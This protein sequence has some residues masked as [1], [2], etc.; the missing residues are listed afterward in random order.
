MKRLQSLERGHQFGRQI[1]I[2][3]RT[4]EFGQN[5]PLDMILSAERQRDEFF[6]NLTFTGTDQ[7]KNRLRFVAETSD[8]F[9]TSQ[10]ARPLEC[11]QSTKNPIDRSKPGSS[12]IYR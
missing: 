6:I 10:A 11:V 8:T 9:E 7:F 2:D 4:A 12:S 3:R 5:H 1:F